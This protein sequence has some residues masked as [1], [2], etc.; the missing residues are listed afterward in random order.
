M[1]KS[2]FLT[3]VIYSAFAVALGDLTFNLAFEGVS[4]GQGTSKDVSLVSFE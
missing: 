4:M 2:I 1:V 3:T